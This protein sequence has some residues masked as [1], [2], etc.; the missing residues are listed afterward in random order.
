MKLKWWTHFL[1]L[2]TG[3]D[4]LSPQSKIKA[5]AGL[6]GL[7]QP[8]VHWRGWQVSLKAFFTTFLLNKWWT[9]QARLTTGMRDATEE[10]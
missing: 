9:A 3:L 7:S 5:P 1:H 4:E 6:A 10:R 2:W 8:V